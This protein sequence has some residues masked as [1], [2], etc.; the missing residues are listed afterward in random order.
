ML[1]NPES[2]KASPA[3]LHPLFQLVG[4][5]Q[6]SL[7]FDVMHVLDQNGVTSHLLGNALFSF[8][9]EDL[10]G[11][12]RQAL[13]RVWVRIQAIYKELGSAHRLHN[14]RLS[15]FCDE[16]SP[17]ASY[18]CLSTAIKATETRHLVQPVYVLACEF[19]SG[20]D[21]HTHRRLCLKNLLRFYTLL[22]AHGLFI[23]GDQHALLATSVSKVLNHYSWL[24]KHSMENGRLQ[25]SL[26]PKFHFLHH[27][28]EQAKF[29]NPRFSWTYMSEDFVG[30]VV[31][32]AR[33]CAPGTG[34]LRLLPTVM[35]KY[36]LV[37]HLRFTRG[38]AW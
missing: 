27:L 12:P 37:Q 17:H 30:H 19:D 32:L 20:S 23:P 16:G 5:T 34:P 1:V 2:A 26:V 24:A 33:S 7:M 15:M 31:G 22:E 14:L 18:P 3:S 38:P 10:R 25:Y 36:R 21:V 28:A 6:L 9:F 13:G 35:Q 8:V 11:P 29:C 4:V